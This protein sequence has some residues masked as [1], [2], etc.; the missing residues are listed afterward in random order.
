MFAIRNYLWYGGEKIQVEKGGAKNEDMAYKNEKRNHL[1]ARKVHLAD[2]WRIIY[3]ANVSSLIEGLLIDG[4]Q[5][6]HD[7]GQVHQLGS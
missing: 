1:E 4:F 5:A 7:A 3:L 2:G 6:F